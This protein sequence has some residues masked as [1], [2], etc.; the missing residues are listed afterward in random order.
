[1][2]EAFRECFS[3][4]APLTTPREY[5]KRT[6]HAGIRVSEVGAA[7]TVLVIPGG[8]ADPDVLVEVEVGAVLNGR[9]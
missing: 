9:R 8:F 3:V 6:G 4:L 2:G 1:M 7:A 5:S